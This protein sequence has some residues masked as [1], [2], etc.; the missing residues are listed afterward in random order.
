MSVSKLITILGDGTVGSADVKNSVFNTSTKLNYS[1]TYCL[2]TTIYGH[3]IYYIGDQTEIGGGGLYI[4]STRISGTA[5]GI[6]MSTNTIYKLVNT[7]YKVNDVDTFSIQMVPDTTLSGVAYSSTLVNMIQ[8]I[9]VDPLTQDIY[10]W[11]FRKTN[12]VGYVMVIP[13]DAHVNR[14]TNTTLDVGKLTML[15]K[16]NNAQGSYSMACHPDGHLFIGLFGNGKLLVFPGIAPNSSISLYGFTVTASSAYYTTQTYNYSA[17]SYDGLNI[18]DIPSLYS[19]V[20]TSSILG[21][22]FDKYKNFYFINYGATGKIYVILNQT[23]TLFGTSYAINTCPLLKSVSDNPFYLD[24]DISNTL[25]ISCTNSLKVLSEYDTVMGVSVTKNMPSILSPGSVSNGSYIN[26]TGVSYYKI[27][28]CMIFDKETSTKLY[29][30]GAYYSLRQIINVPVAPSYVTI[31]S[32][33]YPFIL[34]GNLQNQPMHLYNGGNTITGYYYST[35]NNSSY[36]FVPITTQDSFTITRPSTAPYVVN[37]KS[38]NSVGNS[39]VYTLTVA[40]AVPGTPS[41]QLN[42]FTSGS[43][44]VTITPPLDN[45]GTIITDYDV[46]YTAINTVVSRTPTSVTTGT[47]YSFSDLSANT[48]TVYVSAK[49]TTGWSNYGKANVTVYTTPVYAPTIDQGNTISMMSGNITIAI[50]DTNNIPNNGIY[51]LYSL[52]GGVTYGNSRV[53]YNGNTYYTFTVSDTGNSSIK[54]T[55]NTYS[56]YVAASNPFANSASSPLAV[57]VYTTPSYAPSIDFG[58]TLSTTAGNLTV[59]FTDASNTPL[60]NIVYSYY[61]YDASLG[62]NQYTNPVY[63]TDTAN[64]LISGIT[65]YSFQIPNLVNKTYVVYLRAKNT[66]G[67]SANSTPYSATVY[68]TPSALFAFNANTRTAT[69][70]NLQI[71]ITDTTNTTLNNVYYMYSID[72]GIT[73]SN[74][75]VKNTGVSFYRFYIG[76]TNP[77]L[78]ISSTIYVRASNTV[79]NSDPISNPVIVYRTPRQP[80]QVSF[81]LIQSGNVQ[82]IVTETPDSRPNYYYLNNVSYYLYAYNTFGGTNLSGNTSLLIYKNAVGILS[83]IDATYGNV[84]S[85]INTGLS[86]NTYTMYVI[87]TNAFGNSTPFSANIAVYTTPDY[88]PKFDL[89]NTISA[90]A[91]NVL[92]SITDTSNN[93]RNAISYVYYVYDPFTGNNNSGNISYYSNTNITLTTGT[94]KSFSINNLINRTYTLYLRSINSVGYSETATTANVVIFTVPSTPTNFDMGNTYTV[95]NNSGN[96]RVS[97]YDTTNSVLNQVYYWFSKDGGNTYANSYV[98]NTGSTAP[99]SFIIPSLPDISNIIY[100]RASN[101]VGNSEPL[102]QSFIVQQTPQTASEFTATLVSSGNVLLR[103]RES[104]YPAN[105][106]LNGIS[107]YYY[108]YTE[109]VGTNNSTNISSYTNLIG[110]LNSST[111]PDTTILVSGLPNATSTFYLISRNIVG[112]SQSKSTQVTVYTAPSNITFDSG[113]TRLV[114]SGNVKVVIY[115]PTN[116]T[117]NNV[118]Y[119]YS[120]DG[121]IPTVEANIR[122]INGQMY[123]YF[124]IDG[125]GNNTYTISI[126]AYNT[127]GNSY[128]VSGNVVSYITPSGVSVDVSNTRVVASGNLLIQLNDSANTAKGNVYYWYSLNGS[129][130]INSN[131]TATTP[132]SSP[133]SFY[134]SG[135]TDIS[136]SLS[137]IARNPIGNSAISTISKIVYTT[138][139][140]LSNFFLSFVQ[141]GN[142]RA[143]FTDTNANPYYDANG[144]SYLYY[145]YREGSGFNQYGNMLAYSPTN[146]RFSKTVSSYGFNID[147]LSA[148]TYTLYLTAI[149][150]VGNSTPISNT[151]SV[152][153]TPLPPKTVSI[154][155]NVSGNLRVTVVDTSNTTIN[156]VSYYYY[157]YTAGSGV[158][159]SG[160]TEAYTN[161]NISFISSP[162]TFYIDGLSANNYTVYI[163]SKNIVGFSANTVSNSQSVYIIPATPQIDAGNTVSTNSGE[164][165]VSLVDTSNATL[166]NVYYYYFTNN[167]N[168]YSNSLT[169]YTGTASGNRYSYVITGLTNGQSYTVYTIAQNTMGNSAPIVTAPIIPFSTPDKPTIIAIPDDSTITCVITPPANNGNAISRYSYSISSQTQ[170]DTYINIDIPVDNTFTIGNLQNGT[171]YTVRVI[172]TNARGN[173]LPSDAV[174]AKPFG[175]SSAPHIYAT[176]RNNIIDVSFDTPD[177]NG[178]EIINYRYSLNGEFPTSG[179]VGVPPDNYFSIRYLTIGNTYALRLHAE[180][181]VGLSGPSNTITLRPGTVPNEPIIV[182]TIPLEGAIEIELLPGFDGG[183]DIIGYEYAVGVGGT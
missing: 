173:S 15:Y 31:T 181:N 25:F 61:L 166:N 140:Q 177:S 83:N 26:S 68:T 91:G 85:Y 112:N 29:I 183:S 80:P 109:G 40:L 70:G 148:N 155:S 176:Y 178:S 116:T 151:I 159:D 39:S 129:Q 8:S 30:S 58:N 75:F 131:I 76:L 100:V 28:S 118:Y 65:Q 138:P 33:T 81:Q 46:Y 84:V 18:P 56:L 24:F 32:S 125:L 72:G 163:R 157:V 7:N 143:S 93:I 174:T 152:Y 4:T 160:N 110:N 42:C 115:D 147:Q 36:T 34:I 89:G 49:N 69:S 79:G 170:S 97:L 92:V 48:Y 35:T 106:Y 171:T 149:N 126:L 165:T 82:V 120:I 111:Y 156:N 63:Y 90:S 150:T 105:Y 95:T 164:I 161:R 104:S 107:Y 101:T 47:T 59:I 10:F 162:T 132:S 50:T 45:G 122:K 180:T 71:G 182:N 17:A 158:N 153:T 142:I 130:Y 123:P 102:I 20:T 145:L 88:P 175:I 19:G 133:Y 57:S 167:G 73:Y 6:N 168:T 23:Q 86:A 54:L 128:V 154:S 136:Y 60:N 99:Y 38:V 1:I 135:L 27:Y 22:R 179:N 108:V 14:F 3:V 137:V 67:Y 12:N 74:T 44:S 11:C 52:N 113:N 94:Q 103:V 87:A 78:D 172:A 64:S 124:Y 127:V 117:A 2:E 16:I 134:V 37:V 77:I 119:R 41:V 62:T 96:L 139:T 141:S 51:Y 114:S 121:T 169:R 43:I 55:A 21:L 144:V 66:F 146:I 13:Y 5:Y 9:T 53:A 98:K